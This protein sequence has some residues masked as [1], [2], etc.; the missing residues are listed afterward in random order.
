MSRGKVGPTTPLGLSL[1]F[2]PL[3]KLHQ[4]SSSYCH[5]CWACPC[6]SCWT[7]L[8]AQH[9]SC[10]WASTTGFVWQNYG[11]KAATTLGGPGSRGC[12]QVVT[13]LCADSL[14]RRLPVSPPTLQLVLFLE[15]SSTPCNG[16]CLGLRV[17]GALLCLNQKRDHESDGQGRRPHVRLTGPP[18]FRLHPMRRRAGASWRWLHVSRTEP[19]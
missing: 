12:S 18:A 8:F 6:P 15:V 19:L 13:Q 10:V 9:P 7:W 11:S 16:V 14:L 4:C 2:A 17:V 1:S 3:A 5:W